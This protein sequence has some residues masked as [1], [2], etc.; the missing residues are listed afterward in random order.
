MHT[1][2]SRI[3]AASVRTTGAIVLMVAANTV[4]AGD[5]D[6]E[7][8]TAAELALQRGGAATSINLTAAISQLE[9]RVSDNLA[10][11]TVS[12][13]N[14]IRDGAFSGLSGHAT[15]I[16]NSGNNNVIQSSTIYNFS[17]QR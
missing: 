11:N 10:I 5:F 3:L 15:L 17:L 2:I 13:A 6:A 8:V 14:V 1:S 9:G 7:P 16:Q 4:L 12:G